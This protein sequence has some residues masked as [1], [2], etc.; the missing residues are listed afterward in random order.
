VEIR[1]NI[2]IPGTNYSTCYSHLA[3]GSARGGAAKGARASHRFPLLF[4]PPCK[5]TCQP[6]VAA[7]WHVARAGHH[8]TV[9]SPANEPLGTS[10]PPRNHTCDVGALETSR[11]CLLRK[12]VGIGIAGD[13]IL[14]ICQ[15]NSYKQATRPITHAKATVSTQA[16]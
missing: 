11:K 10:L 14:I 6:N 3:G 5:A 7:V 4:H 9:L 15:V 13:S 12:C 2:P 8:G 16:S 1:R